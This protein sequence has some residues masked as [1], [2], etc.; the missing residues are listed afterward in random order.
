VRWTCWAVVVAVACAL[1]CVGCGSHGSALGMTAGAAGGTRLRGGAVAGARASVT[2]AASIGPGSVGAAGNG[3]AGN[4]T[5]GNGTGGAGAGGAGSGGPG[6]LRAPW[7]ERGILPENNAVADSNQVLDLATGML[8]VMVAASPT[9]LALETIGLR[10]GKARRGKSYPVAGLAL[11]SGYL[12]LYGTSGQHGH[13][14]LDE[15]DP[16]TL[17]MIRSVPLPAVSSP[18]GVTAVAAGPAGSVWASLGSTLLRVSVTTGAV[19]A[20]ADLPGGLDVTDLALGPGGMNLYASAELPSASGAIVLEYSASTGSL[21]VR[22]DGRS[23]AWAIDGASLTAVPGGVWVSFRTGMMGLSGLLAARSLKV[24]SGFPTVN[25]SSR[26]IGTIYG[27]TGGAPSVYGG[28]ALWVAT[29]DG[30]VAC[31]DPATGRVRAE[32]TDPSQEGAAIMALAVAGAARQVAVAI[33]NPA[34]FTGVVII[35]P[36]RDCWG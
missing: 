5:A 22:S 31:V 2:A 7:P 13:P 21:L 15:V 17:G 35:S 8:Y 14:V 10:T 19:L 32:E 25:T 23:L 24:I 33:V 34:G 3:T 16:S 26:G 11:A 12:W 6:T 27:W 4:G 36:P 20:R 30:I 28:G 9:S 1:S 29:E 18:D